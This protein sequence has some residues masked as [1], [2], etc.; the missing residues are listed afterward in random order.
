MPGQK[1]LAAFIDGGLNGRNI[2]GW[3]AGSNHGGLSSGGASENRD[4][5]R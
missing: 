2:H 4:C 5:S 3:V 1:D